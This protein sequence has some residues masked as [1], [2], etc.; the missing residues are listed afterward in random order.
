MSENDETQ[1]ALDFCTIAESEERSR[2]I[3]EHPVLCEGSSHKWLMR[4]AAQDLVL[5]SC[6]SMIVKHDHEASLR[7]L[8]LSEAKKSRAGAKLE[9]AV[10]QESRLLACQKSNRRDECIVWSIGV[11]SGCSHTL[12]MNSMTSSCHRTT[13]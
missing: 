12:Q 1:K 4:I 10:V 9:L 13:C 8:I 2:W 11:A 3:A 6:S 7:S 5:A